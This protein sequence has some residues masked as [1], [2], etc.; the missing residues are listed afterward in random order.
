LINEQLIIIISSR[1]NPASMMV[2]AEYPY[3]LSFVSLIWAQA[4]IATPWH[5]TSPPKPSAKFQS[6]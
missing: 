1:S 5:I 2:A 4:I 6:L 3:S